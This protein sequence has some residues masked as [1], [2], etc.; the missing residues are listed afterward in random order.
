MRRR[1]GV[2]IA[3]AGIAVL[4]A[5]LV[6]QRQ[7]AAHAAALRLVIRGGDGGGL[8]LAAPGDE[9]FDAAALALAARDPAAAGLD[10]F[11]VMRHG[12]VV[13]ERFGHG[14]S[15]DTVIDSGPFARA[16]V[17]LAAGIADGDGALSATA[18]TDFDPG[19][20]R[21]AIESGTHQRYAEY[22][23]QRLWARL[24]AAPAWIELP[25][26]GATAPTDCCFHARVIDWMRVAGLLVNDGSFEDTQVLER[27]WVARM[28]HPLS[29]RSPSGFGVELVPR[30]PG[31]PRFQTTD[32]FFL[33]GPGHWRLWL[34][35]SLRLAV[36]FGA[37]AG[38]SSAASGGGGAP[39]DETRVPNLVLAALVERASPTT[40]ESLLHQLVPGH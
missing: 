1:T 24:N 11:I 34:M 2:L 27:G 10:A 19:R 32:I 31:I 18:L 28:R 37:P 13:F 38:T 33:R 14:F 39:W 7:H 30:G 22:F 26:V 12:H 3:A 5:G 25:A 8:P 23:S 17:A 21:A 35:P 16:L 20:L 4:A 6:W 40:G 36:L 9:H 15:A 29:A